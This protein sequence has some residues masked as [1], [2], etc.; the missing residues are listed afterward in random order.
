[1]KR[2][3]NVSIWAGFGIVLA[4]LLSYIPLFALFPITR[5]IPWVNYL[6]L[7]AGLMLLGAG[8]RR[9]FRQPEQYRGKISGAILGVLALLMTGA[10]CLFILYAGKQLP[11]SAAALHVGQ[12]APAFTL[13]SAD[14]KQTTLAELL[15]GHRGVIL[16]FYRGYW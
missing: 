4:A 15:K 10:F 5:D 3:W 8:I 2:H 13:A 12:P 6:L 7:L 11:A 16:I 1:V 9:A 14:G